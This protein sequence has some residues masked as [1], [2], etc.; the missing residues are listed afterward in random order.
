MYKKNSFWHEE[1]AKFLKDSVD[2]LASLL[3]K[4]TCH[5]KLCP[6]FFIKCLFFHQMVALQKLKNVFYFI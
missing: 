1:I 4:V 5:L 3:Y 6:L 2:I